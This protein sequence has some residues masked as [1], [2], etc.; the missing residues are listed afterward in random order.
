MQTTSCSLLSS[1]HPHIYNSPPKRPTPFYVA[2]ILGLDSSHRPT[3]SHSEHPCS[4]LG[5]HS[6]RLKERRDHRLSD[7]GDM[8]I[9]NNNNDTL[10]T[11]SKANRAVKHTI[12]KYNIDYIGIK[13]RRTS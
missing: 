4:E 7:I 12:G 5:R 10:S 9:N 2:D 13:A 3:E 1:W 8:A 11:Q 6:G